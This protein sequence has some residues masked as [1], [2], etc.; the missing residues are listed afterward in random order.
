M[1]GAYR[2]SPVPIF[3]SPYVYQSLC[4]QVPMF[5]DHI[6]P[7]SYIPQSPYTPTKYTLCFS[8]SV[9]PSPFACHPLC[10]PAP[11]FP[12][13]DI[14][15]I[16]FPSLCSPKI[17]PSSPRPF[18]PQTRSSQNCFQSQFSPM[19]PSTYVPHKCFHFLC[20]QRYSPVHMFPS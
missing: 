5:P 7:S 6:F 15:A 12:S 4:F 8:V 20:S 14:P 9:F 18:P 13:L 16:G 3:Q 19:F 11:L 17:F 10:S 2:C 1:K